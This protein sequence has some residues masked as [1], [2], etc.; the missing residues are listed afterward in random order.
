MVKHPVV[1][2]ALVLTMSGVRMDGQTAGSPAYLKAVED[3][4]AKHEADYRNAY[5]PLAGL[6]YLKPGANS[7]GSA[8]DSDVKLPGRAPASIGRFMLKAAVSGSS[9]RQ[10]R[11]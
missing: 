8:A 11:P 3:W 7:A 4:R 5:V 9:R 1:L 10:D 2:A 6:F